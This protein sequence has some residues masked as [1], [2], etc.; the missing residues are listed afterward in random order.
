MIAA[1]LAAA[2]AGLI[3]VAALAGVVVSASGPS[4]G[5]FP[6]GK[7]IGNSDPISLRAGDTLTVLDGQGTR[8]LRGAGTFSL[9]QQAGPSRRS[10]FAVLTEQRSAQR[11]R[12]GAVRGAGDDGPKSAPNLWYVDVGHPGNVCLASTERVRLWRDSITG[13]AT[14]SLSTDGSVRETVTFADGEMLAP[15]DTS[16]LPVADGTVYHLA[17]PGGAAMGDLH[18]TVLP[19]V[20]AEPEDLAQ[21]L[22]AHGCTQQLEVLSSAMLVTEG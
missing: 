19:S 15:L 11:M 14:Y 12:T 22:I 10:T 5:S 18:F 3:P 21:Q 13:D 9:D 4:A 17:G 7:K 16:V 20:S 8:V 2:V 1:G 6:V